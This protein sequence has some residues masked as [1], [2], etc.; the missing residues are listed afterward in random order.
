MN[1][2]PGTRSESICSM[3]VIAPAR[4]V[5]SPPASNC[6]TT[7]PIARLWVPPAVPVT[8]ISSSP[9]A[10]WIRSKSTTTVSPACTSA[11]CV[12]V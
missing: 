11:S 8:M 1:A 6:E 5:I 7:F 3:V 12:I 2:N 10:C 4:A 9:R